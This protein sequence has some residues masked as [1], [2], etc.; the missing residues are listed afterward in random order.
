MAARS[1]ATNGEDTPSVTERVRTAVVT[2]DRDVLPELLP[3]VHAL[4]RLAY[5][6][7]VTVATNGKFP[8]W[9]AERW[10]AVATAVMAG[11]ISVVVWIF[12]AGGEWRATREGVQE[13][14]RRM[15][16]LLQFQRATEQRLW[17]LN[18]KID[19][20]DRADEADRKGRTPA[21]PRDEQFTIRGGRGGGS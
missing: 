16:S 12:A 17:E 8:H 5:G 19:A 1:P 10:L 7:T 2:G 21:F 13:L 3:Q 15:E 4:E 11:V 20:N 14:N 6:R 18:Q 9:S